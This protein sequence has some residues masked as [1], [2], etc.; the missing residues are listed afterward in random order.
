MIRN[1]DLTKIRN[2]VLAVVRDV[3][4]PREIQS[5]ELIYEEGLNKEE[6]ARVLDVA[7]STLDNFSRHLRDKVIEAKPF[8]ASEDAIKY[9]GAARIINMLAVE[10]ERKGI[11]SPRVSFQE[12]SEHT[13]DIIETQGTQKQKDLYDLYFQQGLTQQKAAEKLGVIQ[14]T[15]WK[16]LMGN[17]DPRYGKH[18][19]GIVSKVGKFLRKRNVPY[20]CNLVDTHGRFLSFVF[21]QY[22]Q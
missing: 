4:T 5:W 16:S 18:H 3:A 22:R 9:K 2:E 15:V 6:V 20:C 7:P 11:H 13:E 1:S 12:I 19:G 21:K 14:P 10:C 8:L 17:M